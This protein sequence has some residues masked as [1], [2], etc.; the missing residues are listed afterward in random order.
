MT[1]DD[2]KEYLYQYQRNCDR[3]EDLQDEVEALLSGAMSITSMISDMPH[4]SGKSGF[5][6]VV[7]KYLEVCKDLN[8][9]IDMAVKSKLDTEKMIASMEDYR[10]EKVLRQ[11]YIKN[12][13]RKDIA[14][15][16]G[17]DIRHIDR[18]HAEGI[19]HIK[20]VL[21]CQCDVGI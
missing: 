1:N 20:R 8:D 13:K 2:V 7:V 10:V 3:Q 9:A 12:E 17:Y 5:E 6:D 18:L 16:M 4:G 11:L 15:S 19:E 14:E 21:E